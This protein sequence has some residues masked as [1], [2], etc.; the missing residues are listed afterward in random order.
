[1]SEQPL[2]EP[3][4]DLAESE[5]RGDWCDMC[6]IE[7][8]YMLQVRAIGH[9]LALC[10]PCLR[11]MVTLAEKERAARNKWAPRQTPPMW[12]RNG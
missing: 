6:R 4:L 9:Q 5:R 1:M 12:P 7:D 8:R 11:L 3:L 10:L 2:V